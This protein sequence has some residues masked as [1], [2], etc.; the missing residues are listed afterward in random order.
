MP[1][2]STAQLPTNVLW[3]TTALLSQYIPPP[4][5]LRS[6]PLALPAVIVKPSSVAAIQRKR[7]R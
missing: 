7:R 3:V 4:Q 5:A 6:V 1:A 2:P